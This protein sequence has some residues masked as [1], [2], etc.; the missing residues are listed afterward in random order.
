[1]PAEYI[2]TVNAAQTDT[3]NP[4][5]PIVSVILTDTKG[6]FGKTAFAAPDAARR[7]ML[8]QALAAINA[9]SQVLA[10]LDDPHSTPPWMCHLLSGPV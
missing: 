8:A 7:E 4:G 3:G 2:C 5:N 9:G 10:V 1:M 6:S